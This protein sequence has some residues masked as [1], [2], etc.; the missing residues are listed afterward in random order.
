VPHAK[1]PHPKL[2]ALR[3][4]GTLNPKPHAVVDGLFQQSSFFD[5]RDLLQVKYEML[6]RV[7]VDGLPIA[8]TA[9]A[10]GFSR[11]SFYQAQSMFRRGGLPELLPRKRGPRVAHKLGREV[12]DFVA[13][14]RAGD[15]SVS[16]AA[17][18]PLIKARFGIE[19][20]RR[21]VERA[22]G[23]QEKKRL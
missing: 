19:I 10:F 8:P 15:S 5:P 13:E 1:L 23:R 16:A 22:L 18:A 9:T 17:L 3:E 11:P 4:R 2:V 12:M 20:H 14:V 7:L 21:S 6:R